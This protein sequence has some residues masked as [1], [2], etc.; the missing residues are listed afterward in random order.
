MLVS[1]LRHRMI[2]ELLL[3]VLSEPARRR[4]GDHASSPLLTNVF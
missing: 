3:R 1:Q 2:E 4:R